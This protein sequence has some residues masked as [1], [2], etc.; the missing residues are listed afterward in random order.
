LLSGFPVLLASLTA[1]VRTNPRNFLAWKYG[2]LLQSTDVNAAK[3]NPADTLKLH[4][5]QCR[6]AREVRWSSR[7]TPEKSLKRYFVE[8]FEH[9]YD[10]GNAEYYLGTF[11]LKN[12]A[13]AERPAA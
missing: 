1:H 9:D 5:A 3:T 8:Q 4:Q 2:L 6:G 13:T 12:R 7:A 11:V 10:N